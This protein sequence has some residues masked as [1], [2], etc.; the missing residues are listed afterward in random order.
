LDLEEEFSPDEIR[1]PQEVARRALVL[2]GT[3]GV[4][5]GA[6]RDDVRE[7][8]TKNELLVDLSPIEQSFLDDP[9]PSEQRSVDRGWDSEC[10]IV[11]A[12][13]LGHCAD[14][15]AADEQCELGLLGDKFPPFAD[16]SVADFVARARLRS[17]ME[18]Q[19]LQDECLRLHAEGRNARLQ[20]RPPRAPVNIEIIQERHRAINWVNGYDSAPWD[21]VTSDT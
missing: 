13:A 1:S 6:N 14:L 4:A 2:F 19:N 21:E 17:D 8:L 15:P 5:F 11:L 16:I 12:W 9:S 18:L 7:W 20:N 3:T 10:L